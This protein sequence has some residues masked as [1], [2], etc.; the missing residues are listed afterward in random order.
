MSK[1]HHGRPAKHASEAP[2]KSD[3]KVIVTTATK[4]NVWNGVN[5]RY[6][7]VFTSGTEGIVSAK[8]AK[9][10]NV[11]AVA[12]SQVVLLH[13]IEKGQQQSYKL[14]GAD[15][16]RLLEYAADGKSIFLN[17][18]IR[19]AIQTYNVRDDKIAES[20][21]PHP[22]PVTCFATSLDSTLIISASENPPTVHIDNIGLRTTTQLKPRASDG[23]VILSAFHPTRKNV[24]LLAF[25]DGVLAA[26][27]YSKASKTGNHI[28]A[29]GHL[30]DAMMGGNGMT[31]AEFI[32]GS[33]TRA[34][35]AGEDGRVMI[36]DFDKRDVVGS[37]HIG[38][39]ATCL[40]VRGDESG[41]RGGG[42]WRVAVGTLHGWCYVYDQDGSKLHEVQVD[43]EGNKVLEVKWKFGD[44]KL[45]VTAAS[46]PQGSP[47]KASSSLPVSTARTPQASK[48]K[49]PLQKLTEDPI[50]PAE[51]P[52]VPLQFPESPKVSRFNANKPLPKPPPTQQAAR[53]E[54]SSWDD[55]SEEFKEQKPA[56]EDLQNTYTADYM[57]IFSPVKNEPVRHS[58]RRSARLSIRSATSPQKGGE[59]RIEALI[60]QDEEG[61]L[62][63][64]VSSPSLTVSKP[65]TP[66]KKKVGAS[67]LPKPRSV[68]KE[69][70]KHERKANA[71]ASRPP[72]EP[73]PE[74][75]EVKPQVPTKNTP[76]PEPPVVRDFALQPAPS[77]PSAPPTENKAVEDFR[78]V[79]A[80]FESGHSHPVL[81]LFSSHMP[82]QKPKPQ[83]STSVDSAEGKEN[84]SAAPTVDTKADRKKAEK[85][86]RRSAREEKR[87]KKKEGSF[88]P[89]SDLVFK[90]DDMEI[91]PQPLE[92]PPMQYL[93]LPS[94]PS[95]TGSTKRKAADDP[96]DIPSGAVAA[97]SRLPHM[98]VPRLV[99]V[100]E[101]AKT[102]VAEDIW[103]PEQVRKP[104]K[105]VNVGEETSMAA[106]PTAAEASA[107]ADSQ[108]PLHDGTMSIH[109]MIADLK[110]AFKEEMTALKSDMQEKFERQ[111]EF[112][113]NLIKGEKGELRALRDENER[114]KAEIEELVRFG[115]N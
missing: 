51:K 23:K 97:T 90:D 34:I 98:H 99:K 14:K 27:D 9:E 6:D 8:L 3:W 33:Q 32:P 7:T 109:D 22:S 2:S 39:P 38:A 67:A 43:R 1:R 13:K 18:S 37:F 40:S 108:P 79:R 41:R 17:S 63:P 29:F 84:S 88:P 25:A 111:N 26:Y 45:P 64:S 58:P 52:A 72:L 82:N 76:K 68:K 21:K 42:K 30:H 69:P 66:G 80:K 46:A 106:A 85:E 50:V 28:H 55:T 83:S 61:L 91:D 74:V 4:V 114:L 73:T 81:S 62:R 44:V 19:N 95:K 101:K 102:P 70:V 77:L 47:R 87:R 105:R 11:L 59:D 24:F 48:F 107:V 5:E 20:L 75:T 94:I 57:S 110:A 31:A 78:K 96:Y 65:R 36:L 112:F 89:V 56:W 115:T 86:R 100:K 16:T 93:D 10:G 35:T 53:G 60:K 49:Q 104:S 113:E 54:D 103:I 92:E 12:G 15:A 71:T